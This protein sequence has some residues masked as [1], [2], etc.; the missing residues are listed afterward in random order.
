MGRMPDADSRS[1]LAN[2]WRRL[3]YVARFVSLRVRDRHRHGERQAF[4]FIA[5][6]AASDARPKPASDD[7][8][9]PP[10]PEPIDSNRHNRHNRHTLTTQRLRPT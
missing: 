4:H 3:E 10:A 8:A 7:R 6:P 2:V 1:D 5:R 9:T